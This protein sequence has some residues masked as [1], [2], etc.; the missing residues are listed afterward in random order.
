[1][2][3]AP[4]AERVLL[5]VNVPRG[6]LRGI[7]TTVQARRNH[8]TSVSERMDPRGRPYYW[9]DEAQDDWE[10]HDQSD[11]QAVRDGFVSV[12]PLHPDLTAHAA[13]EDV[14]R[15]IVGGREA[16]AARAVDE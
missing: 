4:L 7:R 1:M 16:L 10:P 12:T 3:R 13:L 5:N 11:Y 6:E 15:L 2:L 9:I 14:E 8:I